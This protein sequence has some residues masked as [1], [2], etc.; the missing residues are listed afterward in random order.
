MNSRL[1]R[2]VAVLLALAM[3]ATACGGGSDAEDAVSGGDVESVDTSDGDGADDEP[4]DDEPADQPAEI[5]D[6]VE[7][8]EVDESE[9]PVSGGTLR[10][11][12]EADVDGLNPVS[13]AF[14][15]PGLLMGVSWV[16]RCL[17]PLL[18]STPKTS[19]SHTW[20]NPSRQ[21]M[22]SPFGQ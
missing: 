18:C 22:T 8:I 5:E 21:T 14:S 3:V 10:Y 7:L 16:L 11:A 6:T 1:V 15:A 20:P 4:A 12:L 9:E 2:L 13:S 19:G 17:T